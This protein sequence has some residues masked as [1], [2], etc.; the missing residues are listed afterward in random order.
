M[1]YDIKTLCTAQI[2]LRKSLPGPEK[3]DIQSPD[4]TGDDLRIF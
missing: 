1:Q 4:L 2:Y 3:Q